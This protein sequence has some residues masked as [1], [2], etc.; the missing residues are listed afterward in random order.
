MSALTAPHLISDDFLPETVATALLDEI[1]AGGPSFTPSLVG[2]PKSAAS[3]GLRSSSRLPGRVGVDLTPFRTA[4]AA[5]SDELCAAVG[6]AP[7]PVYHTECSIVAHG[8]GDFYRTHVDTRAGRDK[9]RPKHVRVV[10]CV[11]YLHRKPKRFSGGELH[12]HAMGPSDGGTPAIVIAPDHNRLAV[13]PAFF[14]HEVRDIACPSGAFADSRFSINC[15][16][17]RALAS[18]ETDASVGR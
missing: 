7:F 1:V 14:P 5:R 2:G 16:L 13:F 3:S 15:W 4:I 6:I 12:I 18:G 9:V 17:H 8:D 10:S 11:Y